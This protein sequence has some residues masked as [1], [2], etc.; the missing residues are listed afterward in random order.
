MPRFAAN[1]TMMFG[2]WDFLDRF[3]AAAEAGFDAVECQFPYE[4]DADAVAARLAR[5]G[6]ELVMFNVPA[7]DWGAGERGIACFPERFD[8]MRAQVCR[9]LDYARATGTR[10]LHMMS[11]AGRDMDAY[12]RAVRWAADAMACQHVELLIEPLNQRDMPGYLL[13]DFGQAEALIAEL[14]LPNLRLQFDIYHRQILHG[15]VLTALRRLLPVI[16]HVQVASVPGRNEPGSGELDD[17]RIF[18]ALDALG[19][20]G[21]VGCEYRPIGHTLEGLGWRVDFARRGSSM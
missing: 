9:A 6:L 21:A 7:G 20:R 17:F 12:R 19:Y 2:E 15:D 18:K 3:D 13:S 14:A 5:N 8:E 1:L 10:K 16:G 4:A 11:G